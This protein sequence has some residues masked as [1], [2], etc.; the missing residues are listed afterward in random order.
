VV[1]CGDQAL[2]L[3]MLQKAGGRKVSSRELLQSTPLAGSTL[4]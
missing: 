1:A 2:A 4:R 3:H